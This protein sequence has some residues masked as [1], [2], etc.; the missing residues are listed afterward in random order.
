MRWKSFVSF[1]VV[2]LFILSTLKAPVFAK[3]TLW[4]SVIVTETNTA[5][6][7]DLAYG[8]GR[9][10][11]LYYDSRNGNAELYLNLIS[12]G[13]GMV[14]DDIRIT[15][16]PSESV[17]PNIVWNGTDF[18]IFWRDSWKLYY[19]RVSVNGDI[20]QVKTLIAESGVHPSVVW[21]KNAQEYGLTWWG[22]EDIN[23]PPGGARFVRVDKN[24][25][26]IGST[27]LLNSVDGGGYYR[28]RIDT[29]GEGYGVSWSDRRTCGG[30]CRELVFA[31]VNSRGEKVGI[32]KVLTSTGAEHLNA[33]VSNDNEFATVSYG[34]GVISLT[35]VESDGTILQFSP[36]TGNPPY[37]N[38]MGLTWDKNHYILSTIGRSGADDNEIMVASYDRMGS[39]IGDFTTISTSPLQD[40]YPSYPVIAGGDVA[41]AWV[42]NLWDPS[43]NISFAKAHKN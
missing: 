36:L 39:I 28:P 8:N 4:E 27:I 43:Q 14:S 6:S 11:V 29:D 5:F 37:N 1:I 2:A 38:N 34:N 20:I 25:N 15:N 33:M 26:K 18:G 17:D 41:V 13:N 30:L 9:F 23:P 21:N 10:G 35:R 22:N 12:K 3:K 40:Y 19:A 16:D 7:P 31:Y 24:G 32:D 42:S